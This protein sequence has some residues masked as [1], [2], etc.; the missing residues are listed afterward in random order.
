MMFPFDALV[1]EAAVAE[2]VGVAVG[3]LIEAGSV[4]AEA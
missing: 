3:M 1:P 4:N 2:A